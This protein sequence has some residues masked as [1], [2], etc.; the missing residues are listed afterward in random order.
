MTVLTAARDFVVFFTFAYC[1]LYMYVHVS[2]K[3]NVFPTNYLYKKY[4]A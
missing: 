3:G 2:A 4:T 1:V